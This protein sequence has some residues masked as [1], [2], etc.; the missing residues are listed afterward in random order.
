M[1]KRVI[2]VLQISNGKLVKTTRFKNPRYIGDPINTVKI[3]N[4]KGVDELIVLDISATVAKKEPDYELLCA[5]ASEAFMP[6]CYGGGV[7]RVEQMKTIFSIGIEKIAL[8]NAA[9]TN[10]ELIREAVAIFGSQS[11]VASVNLKKGFFTFKRISTFNY[12]HM[13]ATDLDPFRFIK[14][15]EAAG[16]GEILVTFVDRDGMMNG[17]DTEVIGHLA[18]SVDVPLVAL[19]G[20][21]H[22]DHIG[23]LLKT[24]QVSAAAAS[25]LFVFHGPHRAVLI[26]YPCEEQLEGMFCER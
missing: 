14:S 2:P 7:T 4:D 23:N 18:E 15:L 5:M 1:R 12:V 25:S 11:I 21:G 20:A 16:A 10:I 22:L 26:Q 9:L 13:R 6:L 3:Y 17:Y 24:T 19:G 8:N